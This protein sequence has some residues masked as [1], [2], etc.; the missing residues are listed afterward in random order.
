MQ[1]LWDGT[2][3]GILE[4]QAC[5][6]GAEWARGR[7]GGGKGGQEEEQG[8]SCRGLGARGELGLLP[9]R[10]WEPWRAVGRGDRDLGARM[11]PLVVTEGR[12]DGGGLRRE[13]GHQGGQTWRPCKVWL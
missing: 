11:R 3:P 8:R 4:E 5:V 1:R 9:P 10:R 13:R 6:A 7:E 2:R 12:T